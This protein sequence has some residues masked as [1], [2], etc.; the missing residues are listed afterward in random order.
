M[1][2]I[3]IIFFTFNRHYCI[4]R[5][6][7]CLF[8][9]LGTEFWLVWIGSLFHFRCKS[10]AELNVWS[11]GHRPQSCRGLQKK[12]SICWPNLV[13]RIFS[14]WSFALLGAGFSHSRERCCRSCCQLTPLLSTNTTDIGSGLAV[15]PSLGFLALL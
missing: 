14:R 9:L 6:C 1:S 13:T 11:I 12:R 7:W 15:G 8:L 4:N 10:Q 3:S 5:I 2:S